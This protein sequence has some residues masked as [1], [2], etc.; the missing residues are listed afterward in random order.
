MLWRYLVNSRLMT[1]PSTINGLVLGLRMIAPSRT[2]LSKDTENT[3]SG[4]NKTNAPP[5]RAHL[6]P[7][8]KWP[9]RSLSKYRGGLRMSGYVILSRKCRKWRMAN[10]C[11]K[12]PQDG[13]NQ[14]HWG[15]PSVYGF[16]SGIH[17][18]LSLALSLGYW[19]SPV[20]YGP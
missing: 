9:P 16:F 11:N 5:P 6:L 1:G 19:L 12:L 10:L 7:A 17:P 14:I 18:T 20:L 8:L 2:F 15:Q 4:A 13:D 3:S